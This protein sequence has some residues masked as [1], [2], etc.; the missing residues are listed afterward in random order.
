M[1]EEIE[2][3][4][5]ELESLEYADYDTSKIPAMG[6]KLD[7]IFQYNEDIDQTAFLNWRTGF[8][9]TSRRQFVI[10][11]EAFFSTAYNLVQQ[12]IFD[13]RDKKAD[14]WIFPIMFNVVHGIE[15]YLKAINAALSFVLNK[16]RSI[17]DGGHD[18]KALYGTARNLIIEYKSSN[19]C[20]TTEE[21][22]QG[23]KVV[24]K[25]ID[26]IYAKTD[27]MTFAR[28][29]LAKDKQGHFYIDTFENEVIDL[30][31]LA[32]QIVYVYKMLDFIYEMP[33]LD[34][35]IQAEAMAEMIGYY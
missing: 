6:K 31:L 1:S 29:P 10:I 24:G 21:M 8:A 32:E 25:F 17:T 18:L 27:D 22:F 7:T 9:H 14:S 12:C 3:K 13:N 23:I 2:V 5:M 16:E 4:I 33:E 15:V 34:L 35:E 30:A 19:K 11:G 20:A 26:N 28:Y